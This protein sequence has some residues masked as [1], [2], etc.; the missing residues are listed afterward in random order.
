MTMENLLESI[1]AALAPDSTSETRTAAIE[2]CRAILG[3]LGA[4]PGEPLAAPRQPDIG[5]T[6]H[7][8]ASVIRSTPP[9]QLLDTLVAKLRAAVPADAQPPAPQKI[10]IQLVRLPTP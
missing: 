1:R 10:N 2:A 8:I 7:A 5:P 3:A 4:T 6:A 9:D